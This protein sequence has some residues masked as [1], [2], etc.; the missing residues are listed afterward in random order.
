MCAKSSPYFRE[1]QLL[2]ERFCSLCRHPFRWHGVWDGGR[3]ALGMGR[4]ASSTEPSLWEEARMISPKRD[5]KGDTGECRLPGG[6][7]R[8]PTATALAPSTPPLAP[9]GTPWHIQI[10]VTISIKNALANGDSVMEAGCLGYSYCGMEWDVMNLWC[11][12]Y[13]RWDGC[14]FSDIFTGCSH[15]LGER[16][17]LDKICCQN[18]HMLTTGF[19]CLVR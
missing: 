19:K 16:C 6:K 11:G 13:N 14:T 12:S 7:Y 15:R 3:W 4:S 10:I 8:Q 2:I 9:L 1:I 5:P 17:G 18:I